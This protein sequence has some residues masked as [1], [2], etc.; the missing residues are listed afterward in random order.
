MK[1]AKRRKQN[2]EKPQLRRVPANK[3]LDK[4]FEPLMKKTKT[5][6]VKE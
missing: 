2:W 4:I 6:F 5:L 3:Y 1:Q